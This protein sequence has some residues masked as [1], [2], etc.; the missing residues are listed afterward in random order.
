M[1]RRFKGFIYVMKSVYS[2]YLKLFGVAT[3]MKLNDFV[4]EFFNILHKIFAFY[5]LNALSL[6]FKV[7]DC[8]VGVINTDPSFL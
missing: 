7:I 1:F 5:W 8:T 6:T 4:V 3:F 2:C